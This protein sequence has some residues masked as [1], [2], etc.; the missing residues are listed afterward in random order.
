V[1]IPARKARNIPVN[2]VRFAAPDLILDMSNYGFI[3]KCRAAEE[4]GEY[5]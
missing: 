1:D 5:F 2:G 4:N 3:Y